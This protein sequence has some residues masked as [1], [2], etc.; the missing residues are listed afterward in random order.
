MSREYGNASIFFL[1]A[2]F[3]VLAFEI[4]ADVF[5]SRRIILFLC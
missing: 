3:C 4:K 5:S 2:G 1:F